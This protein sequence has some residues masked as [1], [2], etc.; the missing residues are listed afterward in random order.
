MKHKKK[1]VAAALVA[2][3]VP[4]SVISAFET[5]IDFSATFNTR[6]TEGRVGGAS[7][8]NGNI[9]DW[10]FFD[11]TVV[12]SSRTVSVMDAPIGQTTQGPPDIGIALSAGGT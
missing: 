3:V 12:D 1:S 2:A 6:I 10:S 8:L 11:G 9:T 4:V 7:T 5:Q